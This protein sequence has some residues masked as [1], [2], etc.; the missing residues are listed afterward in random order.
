MEENLLGHLLKANDPETTLEIERWLSDDPIAVHD[1]LTLRR[2]LTPLEAGR[3]E[4][5]PPADLWIRTLGRVAEHVVATE[6]RQATA[7][8]NRTD[9]LIRRASI[10]AGSSATA[11]P[12]RPAPAS[13]SEAMPFTPRRR[14]VVATIGLSAAVLVL[15]FPAIVQ[16]RRHAQQTACMDTMREFYRAASG[17]SETNE[18][19]F[20]QVQ[21]GKGA[22]TAADTLKESGY[23]APDMRFACPAGR[24]DQ[25]ASTT[26]ANYAYSLGFRDESGQL[27]GLECKPEDSML[28]I[29][30]DSPIRN[31]G[32]AFPGNHRFGQN[33]LFVGGNVRFCTTSLVGVDGDDIFLNRNGKV[34]A[35][36]DRLDSALGRPDEQP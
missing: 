26:L 8:A 14:N 1:M 4:F 19:H 13:P 17:Y 15:V 2:A 16:I 20:P 28:P 18:G 10:L 27:W 25:A 22:A 9:E 23:L 3:E 32:H 35:G 33:V 34:G 36:L 29:M 31:G 21:E 12:V 11:P 5:E 24:P 7:D 6:G 30:A